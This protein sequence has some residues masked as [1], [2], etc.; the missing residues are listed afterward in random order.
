MPN[1]ISLAW[2]K[3][4]E[5]QPINDGKI[6]GRST[7]AAPSSLY[8]LTNQWIQYLFTQLFIPIYSPALFT[9]KITEFNLLNKSFT[10]NP[11]VLLLELIKE[12]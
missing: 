1:T 10:H 12:N 6:R 5:K 11:Q 9:H 4:L 7:T 8:L 2:V 3:L